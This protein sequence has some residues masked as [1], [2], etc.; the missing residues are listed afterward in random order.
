MFPPSFRGPTGTVAVYFESAA[1]IAVLVL[2]GQVLELRAR[3]R[4]GGAIR[5]LLDLA[6][7]TARRVGADGRDEDVPLDAVQVGDLLRVRPGE[8][9]PVDGVVTEGRS[10]VDESMLT[11]EPIP[12]EKAAGDTVTG[13]TLNGSG[14]FVFRGIIIRRRLRLVAGSTPSTPRS[15]ELM[16]STRIRRSSGSS[17]DSS[18]PA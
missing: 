1:V 16:S 3:E 8:K 9:I 10:A 2:L 7:K 14:S 6:P 12:V 4:T 11:G 18:S 17:L 5:A 13:G 15:W